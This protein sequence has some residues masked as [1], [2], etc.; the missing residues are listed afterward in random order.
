M[1]VTPRAE[2][3]CGFDLRA[4]SLSICDNL[5]FSGADNGDY[6]Y[7]RAGQPIAVPERSA[8]RPSGEFLE[9][10]LDTVFKAA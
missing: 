10:H 4:F 3:E 8:E 2:P 7:A 1:P 6:F 5:M 9:W